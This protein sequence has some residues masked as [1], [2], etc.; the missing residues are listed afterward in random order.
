VAETAVADAT[1]EIPTRVLVL[2]MAHDDGTIVAEEVYPV[3]AACGLSAE[4]VRSCIRRLVQEGLFVREGSGR[5]TRLSATESGMAALGETIERTRLAYGQDAAGRGWDGRWRL[6][7]FAVPENQR[8]ARDA[9]R[10]RLLDLGGAI[11]QGGL[12][13]SAHQWHKDVWGEAQRLGIADAITLATTDELEVGGDGDPRRIAAKLWPVEELAAG[14]EDFTAR[15]AS[16]P[17]R[18]TEMRDHRQRLPDAAFLPAALRMVVAFQE[19]FAH[20]PLLPP[21]L[22]P[23]PWPGRTARELLI[24]SRRLALAI[25]QTQGRPALFRWFDD[26]IESIP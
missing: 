23:R 13:V 1:K 3:A 12:Y 15:F 6:V 9:L 20:D 8:A 16:I 17:A 19:W 2:G 4:Q 10:D 22:V 24:R 25:R 11:L 7:A 14:Y 21:E 26:A 5:T 18:L